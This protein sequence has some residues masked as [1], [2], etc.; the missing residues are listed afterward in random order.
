MNKQFL[1][2]IIRHINTENKLMVARGEGVKRWTKW[3]KRNGRY[4]LLV[5]EPI[6][7]RNKRRSIG[8]IAMIL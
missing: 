2:S 1:K 5:M 4:R 8:N 6:S 7:H 3:M